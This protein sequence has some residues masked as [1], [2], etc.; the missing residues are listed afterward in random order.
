M[1]AT[2]M[3]DT[4]GIAS[5]TVPVG[6][7]DVVETDN[8]GLTDQTVSA[9]GVAV[10]QGQT[11]NVAWTNRQAA[12]GTIT[13]QKTIESSTGGAP[14][15]P[16]N[17]DLSGFVFDVL[18]A[19][20]QNVAAT[21]VT[22][23]NGTASATVP[24]GSYD[25]VE[26][27][28]Q[29]LPDQTVSANGV[30]VTQGQTTNVPWTNRQAAPMGTMTVQ[31]TIE[32]S[33]GGAPDNPANPDLSGFV[34]DVLDAGT[35]NVVETV[36]TDGNGAASAAVPVG[37]YD[38][39][40]TDSQGLTDQTGSVDGIAVTEGQTTNIPWTNRQAAPGTITVQKTI[41][42]STGGAPDNPA[43]P[44]L[45]GFVFD[46]LEAGTQN[47]AAMLVTDGNGA[48]LAAVPVGSYDVVETDSQGL[49]DQTGSVDGIAVTEGQTTNVPWT[50]RQAAPPQPNQDPVADIVANPTSVPGG[51]NNQTIVTIDGSGSSDPDGDM[52]TFEWTVQSG[53]FVNGTT[54]TDPVIQV[55]FPG[56]GTYTVT[57]TVSDG[58]G[59]SDS[60]QLLIPLS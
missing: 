27:D 16:A 7:Y 40:E 32:S 58:R 30:T 8:Q 1:V 51:D 20:T 17:P 47:V 43:N 42:S 56:L 22:G 25:V 10:T 11:T 44:D 52:L 36:V 48:A 21:L 38:V 9:N 45:S 37:S 31:K 14:D 18:E 55:T 59:G 49:T 3:T 19:G 4:N 24:A 5:A 34:F 6:S 2:L 41:E 33:T 57:L 60:T 29:G 50:N 53:T 35:Q 28:S 46:V 39:V 54:S 23:G 15:N 13:V 12:P 26:T